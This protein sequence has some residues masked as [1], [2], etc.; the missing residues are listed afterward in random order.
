MP[1]FSRKEFSTTAA[2]IDVEP[3]ESSDEETQGKRRKRKLASSDPCPC[4]ICHT[5]LKTEDSLAQ[6]MANIH[7]NE[8]P[9][10]CDHCRKVFADKN[11]LRVHMQYHRAKRFAC[12]V[13]D[14]RAALVYE[15]RKH[16]RKH[17]LNE[18]CKICDKQVSSLKLHL[19]NAHKTKKSCP[20]CEKKIT[21]QQMKNHLGTHDDSRYKCKDCEETFSNLSGLRR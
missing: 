17:N 6:H 4:K 20:I 19:Q 8:Q 21:E 2:C 15:L 16:A 13:C 14:Y 11:L 3:I 9:M 18:I 10:F 5:I 7:A 12:N 1:F